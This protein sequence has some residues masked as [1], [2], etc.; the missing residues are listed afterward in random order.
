MAH[1]ESHAPGI[2]CSNQRG[3]APSLLQMLDRLELA[4][5]IGVARM[6]HGMPPAVLAVRMNLR[7]LAINAAWPAEG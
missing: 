4:Y 5:E 2:Q 6:V 7:S 3:V 1:G